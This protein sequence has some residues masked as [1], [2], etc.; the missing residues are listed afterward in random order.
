M[1]EEDKKLALAIA[2]KYHHDYGEFSQ[3]A[4]KEETILLLEYV[5]HE[6]NRMQREEMGL[7]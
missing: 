2:E 5:A 6:A 3:K 4:T 1:N 7:E